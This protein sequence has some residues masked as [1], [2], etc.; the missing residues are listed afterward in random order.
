MSTRHTLLTSLAGVHLA[1][2]VCGALNWSPLSQERL[3]GKVLRV[4]Q[5]MTGSD[6]GYGFFAPDV[7]CDLRARFTLIDAAGRRWTDKLDA[8]NTLES[9]LR[10]SNILSLF[11]E[12]EWRR[13]A[14]G[15]LAGIMLARNP[16]AVKVIVQ[17]DVFDPPSMKDYR[18]GESLQWQ[19]MYEA[20]VSRK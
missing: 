2:V 1:L 5:A 15:S 3:P 16:T 7:G 8:G 19:L 20:T 17:I 13:E 12:E 14:A 18:A 6:T 4:G 10:V 9:R 11:E